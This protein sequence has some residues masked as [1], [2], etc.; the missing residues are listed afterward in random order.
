MGRKLGEEKHHRMTKQFRDRT[1][2]EFIASE[3]IYRYLKLWVPT[4]CMRK[5]EAPGTI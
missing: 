4:N 1:G 5:Q 2:L 3:N